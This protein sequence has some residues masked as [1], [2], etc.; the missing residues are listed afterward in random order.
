MAS[1]G[2][3]GRME[4]KRLVN[5]NV[6]LKRVDTGENAGVEKN[7]PEIVQDVQRKEEASKG[8]ERQWMVSIAFSDGK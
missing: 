2:S 8:S 5:V 3:F 1:K 4:R 7:A 6:L